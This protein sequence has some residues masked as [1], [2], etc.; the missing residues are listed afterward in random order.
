MA[1]KVVSTFNGGKIVLKTDISFVINNGTGYTDTTVFAEASDITVTMPNNP[2][3][4]ESILVV[5]DVTATNVTVA[6]GQNPVFN[7]PFILTNGGRVQLSFSPEGFWI[8]TDDNASANALT[9]NTWYFNAN[10]GNDGNSGLTPNKA[11]KTWAEW[12][13]RVGTFTVLRPTGGTLNWFVLTDLPQTDPVTFKN[14]LGAGCTARFT[15]SRKVLTTGTFTAVTNQ[16]RDT[17]TP[18]SV[19][20]ITP[21]SYLGMAIRVTTG[22]ATGSR[23]YICRNLSG[24]TSQVSTWCMGPGPNGEPDADGFMFPASSPSPGDKFEIDD[25]VGVFMG[26]LVVGY[27]PSQFATVPPG[28]LLFTQLR[29]RN[30]GP[31]GDVAGFTWPSVICGSAGSSLADCII[32]PLSEVAGGQ[33]NNNSF[34]NAFLSQLTIISG[35]LIDALGAHLPT[36]IDISNYPGGVQVEGPATYL[37]DGDVTFVGNNSGGGQSSDILVRGN[38]RGGPFNFWDTQSGFFLTDGVSKVTLNAFSFLYGE[39]GYNPLWG[40]ISSTIRLFGRSTFLI[41]QFQGGPG[42]P[43]SPSLVSNYSHGFVPP[44]GGIFF[45]SPSEFCIENTTFEGFTFDPTTAT[46]TP[47]GGNLMS[48][49]NFDLPIGG[50]GFLYSVFT[51]GFI[52]SNASAATNPNSQGVVNKTIFFSP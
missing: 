26:E 43:P 1:V 37:S 39:N 22:A 42:T 2:A 49:A 17:N 16:N 31:L 44:P 34:N 35:Q 40:Q 52:T 12:Q 4:G 7:G 25:Y 41:E 38:V 32:E 14:F 47:A 46:W 15:G 8:E 10:S 13:R 9:Q 48:W 50:G 27:E 18:N 30:T 24:T 36:V 3:V 45:M 23:A 19:S 51:D 5:A 11:L 21:S 6:G 20:P 29:V 28:V 33:E